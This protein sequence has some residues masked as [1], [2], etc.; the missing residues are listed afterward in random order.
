M[1]GNKIIIHGSSYFVQEKRLFCA[2]K[3]NPGITTP[4]YWLPVIISVVV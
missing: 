2:N 1:S 4:A 3:I